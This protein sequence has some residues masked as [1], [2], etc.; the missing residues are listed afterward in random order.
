MDQS[1]QIVGLTELPITVP[2]MQIHG[3]PAHLCGPNRDPE[4]YMQ[5]ART[6]ILRIADSKLKDI[7]EAQSN[8]QMAIMQN[9]L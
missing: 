1:V 8:S 6:S 9:F 4:R 3:N 7:G 2:R 5:T